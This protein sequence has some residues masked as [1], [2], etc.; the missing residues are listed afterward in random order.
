MAR[1]PTKRLGEGARCSVLVKLLRPSREVAEALPNTTAQQRLDDLIATRLDRTDRQGHNFESVFFTSASIPGVILSCARR[2]CIVREEGHPDALW[3]VPTRAT[4]R[5]RRA[6]AVPVAEVVEEQVKI[7]EEIFR[8]GNRAEDIANVRG[9]GFEVD[10]DNDPAPENVPALWDE[11]P[12]VNDLYEGQSWGW[13]GIDRRIV[14]GGNYNEPSF[15]NGWTPQG[16]SFLDLFL[17]FFQMTWF[18]NVLVAKTCEA[19]QQSGGYGNNRPVTFGEMIRFLGIRLLM[20]TQQG[21]SVKDYWSY[22]KEQ[23]DQETCPCVYNMRS[24]MT[25]TRFRSIQRF[26]MY[27]D[28]RAPTFVD[29]FWEIR[30][31]IKA[32]NAHMANVFLAGWVICLDESMSIWHQKWT[33]PGWIFCPRK[34][35]PFGNEYHTACCALT[36]I[37]FSIDLVEGKDSPPQVAREFNGNGKTGG[38]LMRILRPYFYTG[39]YVVLD[40][41]FCVL[42]AICDLQKVGVYSCA[43]IKKRKYWPKGVPGEAMQA[44]FDVD[45]V[46]VGDCHAIQGVMEG[47]TYNLWGMKEP[48]YVMR[49]MATGGLLDTNE[50]CRM[51]SRRWNNGGVEVQR[52]FQYKCPFDWHFRYRHAVDDHN[53]LRHALPSIED[54]WNTQRWETRVFSFILAITEVNAFLCLRYFTFGKGT[55]PGCPTLL[56][57]RRR[58][59]WQMIN[60][61]WIQSEPEPEVE[62]NIASVHQLMTAP[63]HAKCFQNRRWICSAR[64]KHQQYMCRNHC[65]KKIRTYCTCLP[66]NWLCY[67]CFGQ[68]TREAETEVC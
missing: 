24:Y 64:S 65:G 51:A 60:N 37:L 1:S 38:L 30:Q 54:S 42:K 5:G 62:V 53:N 27:T 33:C 45:G 63:P 10:D 28:V 41:G 18:T 40:S 25:Y 19:I 35:H 8:A 29:K 14:S 57:F 15:P 6:N 55:L 68:H 3:D 34:P 26:L 39:R 22:T 52:T 48:D 23:A 58:L 7:G 16:K 12:A 36:N 4:R 43:L 44:F 59:A 32:W 46:D 50:S 47:T 66:G 61:T 17:H 9:Q 67:N 2:N 21:W 11:A 56:V 20:A 49:M 31:M 13:D